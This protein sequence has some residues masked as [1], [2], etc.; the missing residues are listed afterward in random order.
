MQ[1][2]LNPAKYQTRHCGYR[3]LTG[4][5]NTQTENTA[6][7]ASRDLKSSQVLNKSSCFSHHI[8]LKFNNVVKW[9]ND[10]V[11]L[12][13]RKKVWIGLVYISQKINVC[14]IRKG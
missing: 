9:T 6:L 11:I 7:L 4:N 13:I 1:D 10:F 2:K 5:M 14:S 12:Q 8:T 3:D